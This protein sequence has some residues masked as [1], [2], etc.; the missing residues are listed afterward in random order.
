MSPGLIDQIMASWLS[1]SHAALIPFAVVLYI[2][3]V[4]ALLS[5]KGRK[6]RNSIFL[7]ILGGLLFLGLALS[8]TLFGDEKC[9]ATAIADFLFFK[10]F[11]YCSGRLAWAYAF[12][13]A[14][15]TIPLWKG[16]YSTYCNYRSRG[17]NQ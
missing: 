14:A 16:L 7:L 3:S 10:E 6:L 4:G 9:K 13:A 12:L 5:E 1:L 15:I 17:N 11:N 2:I 8:F